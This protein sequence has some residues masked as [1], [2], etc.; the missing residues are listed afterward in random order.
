[1]S[2][3]LQKV[4]AN[5][6]VSSR[7]AAE[8]F[9]RQGRVRVNGQVVT[10]LGTT[11][12][13]ARDL[14]QVDGQE[15]SA[16][17]QRLV[18][19]LNKPRGVVTSAS[20]PQGRPTVFDMLGQLAS[21]QGPRRVFHVGRLDYGSEGLLLLTN[22]GALAQALTHPS[23]GVERTYRV[24]VRGVPSRRTWRRL[25]RGVRLEDGPV[26]PESLRL[27]KRNR[28]S[29]WLELVLREGRNRLL[30]RLLAA[31]GH[32]V[33]RLIRISYADLRLGGLAPGQARLLTDQELARLDRWLENKGNL[34]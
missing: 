4:L 13:S 32:P 28:S 5:R 34:P 19:M 30:R 12:N 3:R 17:G 33:L 7:R 29:A 25:G 18:I 20:D 26:C 8:E 22:D 15:I 2:E 10:R 24:K 9:I 16:P 1:M 14:I 27:I 11:V 23:R 6:G 21:R 31:V